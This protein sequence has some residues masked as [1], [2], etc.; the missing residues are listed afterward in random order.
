MNRALLRTSQAEVE[1][2]WIFGRKRMAQADFRVRSPDR[3]ARSDSARVDVLRRALEQ[4]AEETSRE[5]AGLAERLRV[6]TDQ[7]SMLVGTD[8]FEYLERDDESEHALTAAESQMKHA[9]T[10][11]TELEIFQK[12]IDVIASL[13]NELSKELSLDPARSDKAGESVV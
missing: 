12:K 10:R 8:T 9:R 1:L 5:R 2:S 6:A 4:V 13:V 7:A 3:D 11:L